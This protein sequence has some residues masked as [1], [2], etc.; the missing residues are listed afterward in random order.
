MK[1]GFGISDITPRLGVQLAGYGPYRNRAAK[2]IVAPLHARGMVLEK[3]KRRSVVLSVESGGTPRSLAEKIR[4]V[5]AAR[6]GCRSDDVLISATHTHSAPSVGGMVGWGEADM[7]YLE[8]LPA[9][10]A[11][12]AARAVENLAEVE[13]RHAEAPC[14][15]IAVNRETDTG[16]ALNENFKERMSP[17][18]RPAHPEHTDPMVRVLIAYA[19]GKLVGLLHHFGCHPVVY[20]EKTASIHGDY[21]GMACLE[22]EKKYSGAVAM[23][24]PGALGDI[25]PKLNHR[26]P[27]ESLKALKAIARQYSRAVVGGIKAATPIEVPSFKMVRQDTAFSR[28]KWSRRSVERKIAELE[29][30]FADPQVSDDPF[31]GG[32]PPL[33]HNGME[34]ARLQGLRNVLAGFRGEKAPNPEVCIHGLRLGP[35]VILGGGLEAYHGLQAPVIKGSPHE[36][37]WL[38]SLV[39]GNGYAPDKAAHLRQGY[40]GD[41]VPLI[42]GELPYAKVYAEL[43][44][45]LVKLAHSLS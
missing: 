20:G 24:F 39:G 19:D 11:E 41:F 25:N 42:C 21:A 16:F 31:T 44:K 17:D 40:S 45:A 2:E 14:K 7:M 22:L 8:T 27:S 4:Q 43:P 32:S 5:V 13:W 12:A 35:V 6:V 33:L 28:K 30:I 36:H 29:K 38:V 1:A 26:V 3:G 23:F 18:W 10:A 15:G 37:T 34:L 9:R